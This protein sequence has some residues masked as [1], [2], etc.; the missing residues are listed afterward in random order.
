MR[1]WPI[2]STVTIILVVLLTP[3][4]SSGRNSAERSHFHPRKEASFCCNSLD[5]VPKYYCLVLVWFE[6]KLWFGVP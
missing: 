3:G 4:C 5:A 2:S 1:V 6:K